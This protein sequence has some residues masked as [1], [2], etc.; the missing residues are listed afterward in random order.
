[1]I[2]P[3]LD[4]ITARFSLACRNLIL[5]LLRIR[6]WYM[7]LLVTDESTCI[8]VNG[9]LKNRLGYLMSHCWTL[10]SVFLN[11][12]KNKAVSHK[13]RHTSTWLCKR[14][15]SRSAL[16][17]LCGPGKVD[18]F[19]VYCLSTT[20]ANHSL[21]SLCQGA[22]R[23]WHMRTRKVWCVLLTCVCRWCSLSSCL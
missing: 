5:E 1:M 18:L 10:Q 17:L 16:L 15:I 22:Y 19:S 2:V 13:F 4:L 6:L 23:H 12:L 21:R 8:G 14:S 3:G 7:L 11:P 20:N 9:W